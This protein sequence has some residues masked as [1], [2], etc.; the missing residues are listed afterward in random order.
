MASKA[1]NKLT[2]Q[3]LAAEL[4]KNESELEA[5]RSEF[6]RINKR[7]VDITR[8]AKALKERQKDRIVEIADAKGEVPWAELIKYDADEASHH[9]LQKASHK[10]CPEGWFVFGGGYVPSVME[11]VFQ[12]RL[13]DASDGKEKEIADKIDF[14]YGFKKFC[15]ET[16]EKYLDVLEPS[17]SQHGSYKFFQKTDGSWAMRITR[18][19]STSDL[20]TFANTLEMVQYAQKNLAV[21]ES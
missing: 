9:Q 13:N 8:R 19:G 18:W 20:R 14:I 11:C 17:L 10:F 1:I 6:V 4:A 21:R 3:E 12:L 15:P 2:D 5:A 16:N 7:L